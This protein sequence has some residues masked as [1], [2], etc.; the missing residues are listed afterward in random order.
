MSHTEIPAQA[1]PYVEARFD[2]IEQ[3]F[4]QLFGF[5]PPKAADAMA[6]EYNRRRS[7]VIHQHLPGSDLAKA[8]P[9]APEPEPT[10]VQTRPSLIIV[11]K[12]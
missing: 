9:L 4:A 3:M 6:Q 5:F 8:T 12:G 7:A 10:L 1:D 2:L 11:P